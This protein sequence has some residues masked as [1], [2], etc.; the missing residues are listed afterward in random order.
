MTDN[1]RILHWGDRGKVLVF[2][3]YF[4]GSAQS[5]KWV[6]EKLKDTFRC[7]SIT[8]PGFGGTPGFPAPSVQCYAQYVQDQLSLLAVNDYVLIGHSMGGK[9]SMQIA[10]DA[11]DGSVEQLILIAPSP[12]STEPI[13]TEEK[14]RMLKTPDRREAERTIA[15]ITKKPL[16][17]DQHTVA[18]QNQL[19]VDSATR[20]WWVLEG[21]DHSIVDLVRPLDLP[22]TVLASEDDP[23]IAEDVIKKK[24][25]S[26]FSQAKLMTTRHAGHLL[27][28][29]ES[30]WVAESI[31]GIVSDPST[32]RA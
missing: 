31:R 13:S 29:E 21:T 1:N 14:E 24:V 2:L 10:A 9:I 23:A 5:W 26:V 20:R 25:L 12:P 27:P 4:G 19:D 28:M 18:V 7:I 6:G 32:H 16:S 30:E 11:A 22:I 15:R 8:L 3:H 17:D